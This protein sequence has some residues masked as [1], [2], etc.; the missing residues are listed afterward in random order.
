[1]DA[2]RAP[3]GGVPDLL[4]ELR[5]REFPHHGRHG[6]PRHVEGLGHLAGRG[7]L[8][9]R[10]EE[11]VHLVDGGQLQEVAVP[12]G[13]HKPLEVVLPVQEPEFLE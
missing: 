2:I 10:E 1:M 6:R 9:P 11:Q 3:V 12:L 5:G 7:P 4:D 13:G 8:Q